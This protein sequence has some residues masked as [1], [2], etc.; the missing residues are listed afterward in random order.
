[1]CA[2]LPCTVMQPD[3]E[4]CKVLGRPPMPTKSTL[5]SAGTTQAWPPCRSPVRALLQLPWKTTLS[6]LW[7]VSLLHCPLQLHGFGWPY[8]PALGTPISGLALPQAW[9]CAAGRPNC[10]P[11]MQGTRTRH[12]LLLG[13]LRPAP[14]C[15]SQRQAPGRWASPA[16]LLALQMPV[17]QVSSAA[18][19]GCTMCKPRQCCCHALGLLVRRCAIPR[20][21]ATC[22][23]GVQAMGISTL[24]QA[25]AC[26]YCP[27]WHSS[28]RAFAGCFF[29]PKP[30]VLPCCRHR[31]QAPGGGRHQ[32]GPPLRRHLCL[33]PL[34]QHLECCRHPPLSPG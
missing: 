27:P 6:S 16:C 30:E 2:W 1:V 4:A 3:A 31:R 14:W 21:C 24:A 7:E 18:L 9:A 23:H 12:L 29:K 11:A 34:D 25:A 13:P 15:T 17:R 8:L 33:R 26:A 19:G 32:Q 28:G 5:A 20:S 22:T 10:G